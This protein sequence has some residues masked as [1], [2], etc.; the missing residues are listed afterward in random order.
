MYKITNR[1]SNEIW[2]GQEFVIYLC[3]KGLKKLNKCGKVRK[4]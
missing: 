4:K 2:L 3:K 1:K